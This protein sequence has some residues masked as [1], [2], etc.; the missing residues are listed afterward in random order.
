MVVLAVTD[1]AWW[2]TDPRKAAKEKPELEAKVEARFVK[3]AKKRGWKTR[4]LNGMG[5]RH[6]HDQLVLAPGVICL[7]E[8]KRPEVGKLSEGQKV[9]HEEVAALGLGS[10]SLVT[11]SS[12]EAIA[13]VEQLCKNSHRTNIKKKPSSSS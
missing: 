2:D 12:D 7:I 1:P 9:H 11:S 4:K 10:H 13:F 8:F 5:A 3:A 6:W